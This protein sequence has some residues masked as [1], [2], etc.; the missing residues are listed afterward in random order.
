[1][2]EPQDA[3][4]PG[5]S[6]REVRSHACAPAHNQATARHEAATPKPLRLGDAVRVMAPGRLHLGLLQLATGHPFMNVGVGMSIDGPLWDLLVTVLDADAPHHHLVGFDAEARQAAE[7]VLDELALRLG[8]PRFDVR[9]RSAIEPHVGLGAKTAL[10]CGLVAGA[11]QLSDTDVNWCDLREVTGRGGTSGIGINVA[12][13]GGLII[14]AGHHERCAPGSAAPSSARAGAAIAPVAARWTLPPWPL[15]LVRPEGPGRLFGATERAVFDRTTPVP[16]EQADAA[17]GI[18]LYDVLP[19]VA[20][21]D[22][23]GFS[24]GLERLQ[25]TAFKAAEWEAQPQHVHSMRDLV[26]ECGGT[27]AALSSMGPT[28]AVFADDVR[29]TAERLR[30]A[31]PTLI[32]SFA[33]PRACGLEVETCLET[34]WM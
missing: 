29:V 2:Y 6:A 9:V 23:D 30:A 32:T 21:H 11:V 28:V 17:A 24:D 5:A 34:A 15:L 4:A 1:V 25:H 3:E 27:C 19:A 22:Y 16:T 8:T 14:D 7:A 13:T 20:R 18:V 12:V 33:S 10:L 31:D 26:F